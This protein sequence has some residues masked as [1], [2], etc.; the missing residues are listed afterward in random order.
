M[1][2]DVLSNPEEA[3]AQ[4]GPVATSG[5]TELYFISWPRR[6]SSSWP[7][8]L[9]HRNALR[10]AV[11]VGRSGNH[12]YL[13]ANS[14]CLDLDGLYTMD[15]ATDGT[16]KSLRY[17]LPVTFASGSRREVLKFA[18]HEGGLDLALLKVGGEGLVEG[19]GYTMLPYKTPHLEVCDEVV[20]VVSPFGLAGTHTF[21]RHPKRCLSDD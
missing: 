9:H 16:P 12:R 6:K 10:S 18:D 4:G 14:R 5:P 13:L 17:S 2:I 15:D 20:A 11:A 21:G 3:P 7:R 8:S 19:K 1:G